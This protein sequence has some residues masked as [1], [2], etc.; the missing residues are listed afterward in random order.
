[1]NVL[2]GAACSLIHMRH[3]APL[4]AVYGFVAGLMALVASHA[5]PTGW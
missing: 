2:P 1:M 3:L 5:L 4:G